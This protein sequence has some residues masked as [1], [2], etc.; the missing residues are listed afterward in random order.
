MHISKSRESQ[1]TDCEPG[2]SPLLQA[3]EGLITFFNVLG[4]RKAP[5]FVARGVVIVFLVG[6]FRVRLFGMG[7][8]EKEQTGQR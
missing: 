7:H 6:F 3:I 8:F 1:P 4:A 5:V 2:C